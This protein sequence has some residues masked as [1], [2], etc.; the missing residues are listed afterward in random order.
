[1]DGLLFRA[2][3]PM[4]NNQSVEIGRVPHVGNCIPLH[5]DTDAEEAT[6]F[7]NSCQELAEQWFDAQKLV[8]VFR[9]MM[10]NGCDRLGLGCWSIVKVL[11]GWVIYK[12][13]KA[14]PCVSTGHGGFGCVTTYQTWQEAIA[15]LPD[16]AIP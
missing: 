15:A 6:E 8:R 12:D 9:A 2:G 1:M 10:S 3:P 16:E 13:A 7:A 4:G 14:W 11:S 5:E